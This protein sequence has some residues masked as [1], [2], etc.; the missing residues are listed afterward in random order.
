MSVA[1][2]GPS[3]RDCIARISALTGNDTQ[4]AMSG[5]A[6]GPPAFADGI[7]LLRYAVLH[8]E[9]SAQGSLSLALAPALS[10]TVIQ[11]T[12]VRRGGVPDLAA[13]RTTADAI[14]HDGA[15]QAIQ[16]ATAALMAAEEGE[17]SFVPHVARALAM[18]IAL[19]L[20]M[21]LAAPAAANVQVGAPGA[22]AGAAPLA[23][24]LLAAAG[25]QAVLLQERLFPQPLPADVVGVLEHLHL[26][27]LGHPGASILG[28]AWQAGVPYRMPVHAAAVA[29]AAPTAAAA[30]TV[31]SSLASHAPDPGA[32][33]EDACRLV[34]SLLWV[35]DVAHHN[36]AAPARAQTALTAAHV[37]HAHA[38]LMATG[39]YT[40]ACAMGL[41]QAVHTWA[42]LANVP[43]PAAPV[44]A[45]PA[46][47]AIG[48]PIAR[49]AGVADGLLAADL[50]LLPTAAYW[51][52]VA[53]CGY[54]GGDPLQPLG[55]MANAMP[56]AAAAL[57]P[58]IPAAP[59]AAGP[60]GLALGG[61]PMASALPALGVAARFQ[62]AASCGLAGFLAAN[63]VGARPE[64]AATYLAPSSAL[65][66][67]ELFA[68]MAAYACV[69][70]VAADAA[71]T[72]HNVCPAA[73]AA[74]N[75]QFPQLP[76]NQQNALVAAFGAVRQAAPAPMQVAST[77]AAHAVALL[78]ESA[79]ACYAG[80]LPAGCTTPRLHLAP[81]AAALPGAA[82]RLSLCF[83]PDAHHV[84]AGASF[85][86][87]HAGIHKAAISPAIWAR[88]AK[89][90]LTPYHAMGVIDGAARAVG[91]HLTW[92]ARVRVDPDPS[93]DG[94]S[95]IAPIGAPPARPP[96][97]CGGVSPGCATMAYSLYVPAPCA[98]VITAVAPAHHVPSPG[99]RA[100]IAQQGGAGPAPFCAPLPPASVLPLPPAWAAPA[101]AVLTGQLATAGALAMWAVLAT[102]V[103]QAPDEVPEPDV[104]ESS[105]VWAYSG[106]PFDPSKGAEALARVAAARPCPTSAPVAADGDDARHR[107]PEVAQPSAAHVAASAPTGAPTPSGFRVAWAAMPFA[108]T[109]TASGSR[110][111]ALRARPPGHR[112]K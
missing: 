106:T 6:G 100:C 1:H 85:C 101:P 79:W 92:G 35:G 56:A 91:L 12:R 20:G 24:A 77:A 47:G 16:P 48:V 81:A 66:I 4:L 95:V 75:A 112:S 62:H 49:P 110:R 72:V 43:L 52:T 104:D 27:N 45:L 108:A 59:M 111:L 40:V 46:P 96:D 97:A 78:G 38:T 94:G 39:P 11:A 33:F 5:P 30:M 87:G 22:A 57:A 23:A 84:L 73:Y 8:G 82:F 86:A 90:G 44:F 83:G 55:G 2:T 32:C 25:G 31:A 41:A 42:T 54:A 80:L 37:V 21:A 98:L 69:L 10:H 93:V 15:G 34:A 28:A 3:I 36:Q 89:E 60:G 67:A 64:A 17:A 71:V 103:L 76:P 53:A 65:G 19:H 102:P 70:R 58:V 9:A 63:T 14:A 107:A 26:A 18:G 7:A 105:I 74:A 51:A 99:W 68:R 13:A 109:L 50:R 61:A 88:C 29:P